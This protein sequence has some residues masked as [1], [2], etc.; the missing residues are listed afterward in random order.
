MEQ[1]GGANLAN[2][3]LNKQQT[4]FSTQGPGFMDYVMK[5]LSAGAPVVGA[6]I[7]KPPTTNNYY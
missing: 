7:Q 2:L 1:S 5:I 6:A 3:A 4:D